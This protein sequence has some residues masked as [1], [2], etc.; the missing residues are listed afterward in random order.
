MS[1]DNEHE[2]SVGATR[3][4]SGPD[5]PRP[6]R[7]KTKVPLSFWQE[8]LLLVGMAM[9][10]ALIL[11]T[12]LVQAFYIPSTSMREALQRDD[13]IL[14]Q[15][16]SYW[17]GDIHRGD[18]VVFDDPA[19]WLGP[20]ESQSASNPLTRALAVVGL[21]PTGGHL[22][23]RVIGIGGDTVA[24]DG[25]DVSVNGQVLDESAY[26]TLSLQSCTGS[27]RVNVPADHL[28]VL[29]DNR[30]NSV[31]SRAHIGDP[32]GGFIPEDSVVGKVFVVM[33]PPQHWS[34]TDRPAI[35]DDAALDQAAGMGTAAAP[36]GLALTVALVRRRGTRP[37]KRD[38]DR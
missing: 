7:S 15:K 38:A 1:A 21:Y 34:L 19:G 22:V 18:V 14:V 35:F 23:K 32:G 6:G 30:D 13:R 29:G 17:F 2:P 4:G 36:I 26:V 25:G 11:K 20:E 37:R 16:V 31:D 8:S 3:S 24:C 10:L 5:E 27:W 28:W 33:W 12:F 9:V